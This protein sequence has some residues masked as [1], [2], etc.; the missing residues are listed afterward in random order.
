VSDLINLISGLL[1]FGVPNDGLDIESLVPMVKDQPNRF[2]LESLDSK[3][4]QMLSIQKRNFAEILDRT[5]LEMFCFYETELSP[6]AIKVVVI[7]M[8]GLFPANII[9]GS[10]HG[11]IQDGRAS[12]VSRELI[13][14]N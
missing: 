13:I 8:M 1:F 12:P 9:T 4:S 3:N 2:L 7:W 14:C 6:I 10:Y 11:A 5:D